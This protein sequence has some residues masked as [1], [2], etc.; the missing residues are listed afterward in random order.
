M[1]RMKE[2][3]MEGEASDEILKVKAYVDISSYRKKVLLS[4]GNN[5][6]M[7]SEIARRSDI[8]QNHIS[9]TLRELKN[10]E[11]VVCIN[12]EVRKGR[13]YKLTPLGLVIYGEYL[14]SG[15]GDLK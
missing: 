12:E 8:R 1:G 9:N 4:I 5:V 15:E 13:L 10:A 11:L 2:L 7:P 6:L 14:K 3:L